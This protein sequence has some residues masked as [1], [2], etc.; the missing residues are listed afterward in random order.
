M[1]KIILTLL[2]LA[3]TLVPSPA[4]ATSL[5]FD[6]VE[7]LYDFGDTLNI[8]LYA[9]IDADDAIMGFGFDLSFDA[10]T[11]FVSGPGDSGSALTF[12]NFSPNSM[13]GFSYDPFYDS[14]GDTISGFLGFFDPDVSGTSLK[15]GSFE[16]TAF[17]LNAESIF[18]SA[19]DIGSDTSVEGLVPGFTALDF[20]SILPNNPTASAAPVPEPATVLLVASGLI[21]FVGLRKKIFVGLP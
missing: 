18:L 2:C 4:T 9:D 15:L 21:G 14:D 11:T 8:D 13:L 16:F 10:G 6:P 1:R 17:A 5:W 7:Q 12:Q 20:D 19:D 3:F